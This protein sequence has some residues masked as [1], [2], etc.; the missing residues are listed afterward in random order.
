MNVIQAIQKKDAIHHTTKADS[1]NLRRQ[2]IFR[3]IKIIKQRILVT[4]QK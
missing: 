4:K 3:L 2:E 1:E